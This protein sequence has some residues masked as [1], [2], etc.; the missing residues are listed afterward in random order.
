MM[1]YAL[2][3]VLF[4]FGGIALLIL[5]ALSSNRG[6]GTASSSVQQPQRDSGWGK[7]GKR[8]GWVFFGLAIL[9][10][11]RKFV[12]PHV[13]IEWREW[14]PSFSWNTIEILI[15]LAGI[16]FLLWKR[17]QKSEPGQQADVKSLS[18]RKTSSLIK[19]IVVV[20]LCGLI[21][22]VWDYNIVHVNEL[23]TSVASG[24]LYIPVTGLLLA[25]AI[26]VL[27]ITLV[28]FNVWWVEIPVWVLFFTSLVGGMWNHWFMPHVGDIVVPFL[29]V[30]FGAVGGL[31]VA[32]LGISNEDTRTASIIVFIFTVAAVWLPQLM[33]WG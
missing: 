1:W 28:S 15:V 2:G 25:G 32:L 24:C 30:V 17:D 27:T 14:I 11:L 7:W 6:V 3:T 22:V 18:P 16:G 31:F 21:S 20:L 12:F 23:A 10:L 33:L 26:M 13:P 19:F 29:Y 8:V 5:L 9:D 4:V